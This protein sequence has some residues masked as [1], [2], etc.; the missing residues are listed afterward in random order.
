LTL[1]AFGFKK[2]SQMIPEFGFSDNVISG[3]Q[4]QSIYFGTWV[5]L[6]WELSSHNKKL[7]DL[8]LIILLLSFVMMH[9]LDLDFLEGL[10]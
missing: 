6:G 10:I 9:Q 8:K 2:S 7:S 3:E 1:G 4:S 5:L